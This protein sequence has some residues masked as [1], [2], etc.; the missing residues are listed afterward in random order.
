MQMLQGKITAAQWAPVQEGIETL[1]ARHTKLELMAEAVA[2][3]LLIAPVLTPGE[4]LDSPHIAARDFVREDAPAGGS[5]P[6][7]TWGDR[8]CRSG[9]R[10][11]VSG[12]NPRP[13]IRN[14]RPPDGLPTSARVPPEAR[15]SASTRARR[16]P[17][18][19]PQGARPVLGRRG[20]GA[21]G[22]LP[23]TA[24]RSCTSSPAAGSTWS[25]TCRPTSRAS[26][27][28]RRAACHH[29]TNC[30]KLN[31]TLDLG[32]AEGRVGADRPDP[33]ADVFTESFAPGVVGAH[34]L[35]Y[36]AVRRSIRASS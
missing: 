5:G 16:R 23:T 31:V 13:R 10:R 9:N 27:T 19:R 32:S 4:L 7:P 2:R 30:N 25:A 35:R 15:R 34:G 1:V 24:R 22:C 14:P 3:R 18:G 17:A 11:R 12:P 6:L 20:P 8:R 21:P 26:P 28:P 29:T 36:E 33:L